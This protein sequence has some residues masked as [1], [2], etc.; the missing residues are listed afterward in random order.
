[1]PRSKCV[2]AGSVIIIALFVYP[3]PPEKPNE[4]VAVTARIFS[5]ESFSQRNLNLNFV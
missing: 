1:V 4:N 5:R 2:S 3:P